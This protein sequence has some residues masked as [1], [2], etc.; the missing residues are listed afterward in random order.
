MWEQIA[1]LSLKTISWGGIL[2]FFAGLITI[3]RKIQPITTLTSSNFERTMLTKE[4][5][6]LIKLLRFIFQ[7]LIYMFVL[8][9][10]LYCF[11]GLYTNTFLNISKKTM[12]VIPSIFSFVLFSSSMFL[13]H[14]I[15]S[16]KSIVE[17]ITGNRKVYVLTFLITF[18]LFILSS[19]LFIPSLI[20]P[21]VI[22][23]EIQYNNNSELL[24]V[25]V[26]FAMIFFIYSIV[27]M[28]GSK[29]YLSQLDKKLKISSGEYFYIQENESSDKWY[30]YYPTNSDLYLLGDTL[31]PKETNVFR[32]MQK[33]D[34][35][36]QK[37]YV[38]RRSDEEAE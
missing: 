8:G 10:A 33:K 37:I 38:Q 7:S 15:L 22:K 20:A 11:Y 29:F 4:K 3:L 6:M 17:R 28:G 24:V 1:G 31:S 25:V 19:T 5:R 23:G 21:L 16:E 36:A 34:L 13:S 18:T 30:V 32:T 14:L 26:A 12:Q 27:M 35:L 9:F 2:A